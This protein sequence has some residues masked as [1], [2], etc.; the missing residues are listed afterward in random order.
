M[1]IK[2]VW[3]AAATL[4]LTLALVQGAENGLPGGHVVA[5][6]KSHAPVGE[7]SC[8][9]TPDTIAKKL[10]PI[11]EIDYVQIFNAGV[12][13]PLRMRPDNLYVEFSHRG[14]YRGKSLPL[15]DLLEA[16]HVSLPLVATEEAMQEPVMC[17]IKRYHLFFPDETLFTADV[18]LRDEEVGTSVVH[19]LKGRDTGAR[20]KLSLFATEWVGEYAEGIRADPPQNIDFYFVALVKGLEQLVP[21]FVLGG[22]ESLRQ[23]VQAADPNLATEVVLDGLIEYPKED[24]FTPS[25]WQVKYGIPILNWILS[26]T[27]KNNPVNDRAT[28]RNEIRINNLQNN[29]VAPHEGQWVAPLSDGS[30][31]RLFFYN[32]GMLKTRKVSDKDK[33]GSENEYVADM[34]FLSNL[35]YRPNL[36]N[37]GC[38]VY[39]D[40]DASI[41]SIE[42][43]DGSLYRPGE[44]FWEWAKLKAR[45]ALFVNIQLMHL[46]TYHQIWANVPGMALRKF[47]QPS[48]PVRIALTPHF[49]RTHQTCTQAKD[50]LVAPRGPLG[51][52]LP[53]EYEDGHKKVLKLLMND[54]RFK[55]WPDELEQS[56]MKDVEYVGA[57]DAVSLHK[58][59]VNYVSNLIDEIY[60]TVELLE[61]DD[62]M[63]KAYIY[64]SEKMKGVPPEFSMGNLKLVWGE[65]LF[66]ITGVHTSIGNAAIAALEPFFVN[67]RLH[68]SDK[69]IVSGN[70][71]VIS[72]VSTITSLTVPNEYPNLAKNWAHVLHDP[73]SK[74]YFQLK[75]D[76]I[77]HGEEIDERN[78]VRRFVN[79]DFHP[80][81]VTLSIFS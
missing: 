73:E 28:L 13:S 77:K 16:S 64:M 81:H 38:K 75:S 68:K 60:P 24:E 54:Y 45:S 3:K 26:F 37:L 58:I 50:L 18:S 34:T 39:F 53:F 19:D 56:G 12:E 44:E 5:V 8:I 41:T 71:E 4:A 15:N 43:Y 31:H 57:T 27:D 65:I 48:H 55:T 74:A 72:T 1:A 80:D 35:S 6:K 36:E 46:V 69:G 66:R 42:D 33:Y 7:G 63:R 20:I 22:T 59:M 52:A 10:V 17:K 67:F 21:I 32:N 11:K 2:T 30:M 76:L 79:R 25:P 61:A 47:L 49:F 62:D 40:N 14:V 9:V 51:R 29:V 70:R 78:K 23:P